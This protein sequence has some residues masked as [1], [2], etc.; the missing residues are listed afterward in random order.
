[1]HVKPAPWADQ[2]SSGSQSD[3][4]ESEEEEEAEEEGETEEDKNKVAA[5]EMLLI[6]LCNRSFAHLK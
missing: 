2:G 3:S 1:M 4:D 6:L 5:R